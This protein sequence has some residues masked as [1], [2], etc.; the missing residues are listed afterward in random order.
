MATF[1][2]TRIVDDHETRIWHFLSHLNYIFLLSSGF[3][4]CKFAVCCG[5]VFF[6]P[7]CSAVWVISPN[8]LL[9][10]AHPQENSN[11]PPHFKRQRKSG[12]LNPISNHVCSYYFGYLPP[13]KR[14]GNIS[15]RADILQSTPT[16]L[17]ATLLIWHLRD[18]P[19][20]RHWNFELLQ[21]WSSLVHQVYPCQIT[22]TNE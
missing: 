11:L 3:W 17:H 19:E 18:N 9:I 4:K 6:R 15:L 20:C 16:P 7:I 12:R 8:G 5:A 22:L 14:R 21:G 13:P 10:C 2:Y 1:L